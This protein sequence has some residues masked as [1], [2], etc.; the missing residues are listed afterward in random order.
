MYELNIQPKSPFVNRNFEKKSKKFPHPENGAE[1]YDLMIEI[2]V[3]RVEAVRFEKR[4]ALGEV[5][6]AE[7]AVVR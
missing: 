2:P 5:L 4:I 6:A 3:D 1:V 7:K